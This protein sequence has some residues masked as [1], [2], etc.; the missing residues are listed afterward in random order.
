MANCRLIAFLMASLPTHTYTHMHIYT[1]TQSLSHSHIFLFA[2]KPRS[3]CSCNWLL[4]RLNGSDLAFVCCGLGS[5]RP[6]TYV[7]VGSVW[8]LCECATCLQCCWEPLLILW[9]REIEH[10]S[11]EIG[12]ETGQQTLPETG[13]RKRTA[14]NLNLHVWNLTKTGTFRK[15]QRE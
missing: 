8:R 12:L 3:N 13:P 10:L 4:P 6:V 15:E 5:H 14:F 11:L 1:C 7:M 9:A 2:N